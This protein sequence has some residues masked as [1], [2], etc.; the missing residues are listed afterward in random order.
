MN[1]SDVVVDVGLVRGVDAAVERDGGTEYDRPGSKDRC[2]FEWVRGYTDDNGK[3][4]MG[5][6]YFFDPDHY[7]N[8]S[9]GRAQA[10]KFVR[11]VAFG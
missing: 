1:F 2:I 8:G 3:S 9:K 4:E 7:S 5:K 10:F 11:A 6:K